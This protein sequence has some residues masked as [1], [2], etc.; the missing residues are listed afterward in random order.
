[1]EDCLEKH[2]GKQETQGRYTGGY[3]FFDCRGNICLPVN[4]YCRF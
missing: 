2:G 4:A 3:G 1:M